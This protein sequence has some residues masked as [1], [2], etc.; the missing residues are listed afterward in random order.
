[1][2]IYSDADC[3]FCSKFHETINQLLK[4]YAGKLKVIYRHFPL[5]QLHPEAP[6]KAEAI[7][8]VGELGGNTKVWL[9][10]D[11]LFVTTKPKLT[12][13]GATAKSIGVD[14]TKFQTC[15]DSGKYATKV[16][17]QASGAQTAGAQGTP[18]SLLIKGANVIPINGAY[19]IA[20]IKKI[21]DDLLK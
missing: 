10:L 14:Q 13:L 8:C 2:I 1:M 9:F 5:A 15:L 7:E 4:D 20:E 19:P 6:K 12:E 21:L 3:P 11:K 16:S 18:Y 17:T